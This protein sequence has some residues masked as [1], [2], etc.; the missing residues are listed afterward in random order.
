MNL[1][2]KVEELENL[3]IKRLKEK[4]ESIKTELPKEEQKVIT[5]SK[6]FTLY[7][8]NYCQNQCGYCFYNQTIPKEDKEH[9][10][11][12]IIE[13][14]INHLKQTAVRCG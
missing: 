2:Q 6:N 8:S 14:E 4:I 1:S 10:T 13:D 3:T 7:L 12:L 11:V 5:F 9:N